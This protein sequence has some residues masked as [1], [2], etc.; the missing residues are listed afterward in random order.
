M[1]RIIATLLLV[2]T[3]HAVSAQEQSAV[4]DTIIYTPGKKTIS[5]TQVISFAPQ[6]GLPA[7]SKVTTNAG[8]TIS[9]TELGRIRGNL[10]VSPS[11][12]ATYAIRFTLPPGIGNVIPDLGL[13]YNSQSGNGTAG[14]GWN[15]SGL[16]EIKRVNATKFHDNTSGSINFNAQDRFELNGQRL[17]LK[18]GT[19]GTDGAEYITEQSSN[20]RIVSRGILLFGTGTGPAY[21]E[22]FYPDGSKATYGSS[23]DSAAAVTS[24]AYGISSLVNPQN[25]RI[26]YYYQKP[27]NTLLIS[28]IAYG[29]RT[30][31]P[32][33][34]VIN[35]NYRPSTRIEQGYIGGAKAFRD[36]I[37]NDVTI[38]ANGVPYRNYTLLHDNMTYHSYERLI[39]LTESNGNNTA[40]LSPVFFTYDETQFVTVT[41]TI[42][43]LSLSGIA[44]NNASILTA[45]F[46]GNGKMDFILYPPAKNKLFVFWDPDGSSPYSAYNMGYQMTVNFEC[47]LPV[48]W[49]T[50]NNKVL[51]GEGF[52]L[53]SQINGGGHN[54]YPPV[55]G[56]LPAPDTQK[57]VVYSSG[58]VL[59]VY[60]QYERKWV[61]D[62]G[63]TAYHSYITNKQYFERNF[64]S[65]EWLSGD[66]DGD[67]LSDVIGISKPW[68]HRRFERD[69]GGSP[70]YEYITKDYSR[71]DFVNID[72]RVTTNFVTNSGVLELPL[73]GPYSIKTGDFN[74][75]GKTDFMQ[76][77]NGTFYV[78]SFNENKALVKLFQVS[79][80][81]ITTN[82]PA[83][84][85]DYNG[86]GKMDIIFPAGAGSNWF[87]AF[88]ATGK[89]F[90]KTEKSY[91]F[92]YRES[93]YNG[94]TTV[95]N[96][97]FLVSNDID[98]D[99]K[100]D[101]MEM[102]TVSTNGSS[103][104]SMDLKTW[105]NSNPVNQGPNLT[106]KGTGTTAN[107]NGNIRHYPIPVFFNSERPNFNLELGVLSDNSFSLFTFQKDARKETMLKTIQE[108]SLKFTIDYSP[109]MPNSSE[110]FLQLYSTTMD[111]TFPNIDIEQATGLSVVKKLKRKFNGTETQ[112]RFGYRGAVINTE[113]LGFLGFTENIQTNWH[114]N[115]YDNNRIYE[116]QVQ[117]PELRG[118]PVKIFV[119][120]QEYINPTVKNAPASSD[121]SSLTDYV[122]RVDYTYNTSLLSNKIFINTPA[123]I[124][125]KNH[126]TAASSTVS[127]TYDSYN[128]IVT[129]EKSSGTAGTQLTSNVF[130]NNPASG[131]VGRL[132]NRTITQS[133]SSG[134]YTSEE[135][136]TYTSFLPSQV[137]RRGHNTSF[138]TED[139]QYDV[140]GNVIQKTVTTAAGVRTD[141]TEYDPSGRFIT[142]LTTPD[143]KE[144]SFTYNTSTG[145]PITK[146]EPDNKTFNYEYDNWGRWI[147]KTDFLG[148]KSFRNF[149]SANGFMTIHESNADSML[150]STRYNCIGQVVEIKSKDATGQI[151]G[152]A[153][154][155]DIYGRKY[156]ESQPAING[157]YT[158]WD[159]KSF[160]NYGRPL[161]ISYY[162]G[163]T[164]T[165][166]YA[167]ASTTV[168]DGVKSVT[169]TRNSLGQVMS[170]QDPG[171]TIAYS[172]F[173][174][175]NLQTTTYNGLTQTIEQDGWGRKTK[176]T[177][178]SAGIYT[179]AY[180]E[181]NDI[182]NET[183]PKGSI[184][185]TYDV[186]GK[187]LS[188]SIQGDNTD[189][190]YTYTYDPSTKLLSSLQL[191]NADGNNAQ[192]TYTYDEH[193]RISN[194]T[195]DNTYA[196][197]NKTYTYTASGRVNTLTNEAKHK[198]SNTTFTMAEKYQYTNG[199]LTSIFDN[200]TN[201]ELWKINTLNARGQVT[202]A[203]NSVIGINRVFDQYGY[204]ETFTST[205]LS[206]STELMQL[207]FTYDAQKGNLSSR[208]NDALSWNETFTY[209]NLN[210]LTDFNDNDANHAQGYDNQ[211]RISS[212]SKLGD[213]TYQGN[214]YQPSAINNLTSFANGY[215]Q[216]RALLQVTYNSFRSPVTI[217]EQGKETIS[218]QYNALLNRAHM[219]FG[220]QETNPLQR[221]FHRHYSEDGS[222][223][224]TNDALNNK[225]SFV[226]YVGGNAYKAPLIWKVEKSGGTVTS[227]F[228]YL[229]RDPQGS[230]FLITDAAGTIKE[231]RQ[232]DAWGKLVRLTD[233]TN[234]LSGFVILDR[235]YTGHEHLQGVMLINMNKRL[236]DPVL[237][238]FL[239]PDNFVQ[240]PHFSQ[241]FNRYGYAMNN[242]FNGTD[243]S[244]DFFIIDSWIIGFVSSL[245]NGGSLKDAFNEGNR[246]A[247][248]DV[249]I[250]AG[251]F[252]TDPNKSFWQRLGEFGSRLTWQLPQTIG[253][254]LFS[255]SVNTFGLYGGVE[256]VEYLYGAT[257]VTTKA[258]SW[259]AVTQGSFIVGNKNLKADANNP[260]FQHEYGHYLQSQKFGWAYYPRV[261]IPSAMSDPSMHSYHPVE[262]D[263]NRRAFIYFNKNVP[264][265]MND[266]KADGSGYE[267]THED[268]LQNKG[269]DYKSNPL[270]ISGNNVENT[271]PIDP[272]NPNQMRLLDALKISPKWFDFAGWSSVILPVIIGIANANYYQ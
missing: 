172:Y 88:L 61:D 154:Q 256:S 202:S 199:Q 31:S 218:F 91:P 169:T 16:S 2:M 219:H 130:D 156:K 92:Y 220:G 105:Y 26:D 223:E 149:T 224:I 74:G 210:R 143:G 67:G 11:G 135:Q 133:N 194:V 213:I 53:T 14:Y 144:T 122:S 231:K 44:G 195:E 81:R 72:R 192:Y 187:L 182:T 215:F 190:G 236:Y 250:Y 86:D 17:I 146:K 57:I 221:R 170:V 151:V 138:I 66:F 244:G 100:T 48:T 161:Q 98:K 102:H 69:G 129:E 63:L 148:M 62:L 40:S 152:R 97:Y 6:G 25:V 158:Q 160:D 29:H 167:G 204:P 258:E 196:R 142:K 55:G 49:L 164:T 168:N 163:K 255:Q 59:P 251:L 131:Y 126:L 205:L 157:N 136:F 71:V 3:A 58:Y 184:D 173:A 241:S 175:G 21:F 185:F 32:A 41:N 201:Q 261:G 177:D 1:K 82:Y 211:G 200:S 94:Q 28:S 23:T 87:T 140:F 253:G 249:R 115:D 54:Y 268:P 216:D 18:S 75:D 180:N 246:R 155:Y 46:T 103:Q 238:R 159:E 209:D 22:V 252:K 229:H 243:P 104:G 7:N 90:E 183:N 37:L 114:I 254:L 108:D 113:G 96:S 107:F 121:G 232:F 15:V 116:V 237:H 260:L 139:L 35:F 266:H 120:K 267:L 248:N 198:A 13:A 112:K 79:D 19:Y 42:T 99:G 208:T 24:S 9:T 60:Y 247:Q 50:H 272:N 77:V 64:V 20:I 70:Y 33:L 179:Y 203:G 181:F 264:G 110:P 38:V 270:K 119:A 166:T 191:T 125:S 78:Y 123:S 73:N 34:N 193:K 206:T 65:R 176:L 47:I 80:V 127:F 8:S 147:E 118:A 162:T 257:V 10:E 101:I 230:I 227:D 137:K 240:N 128:N 150:N 141:L 214:A 225:N 45:D 217:T 30:N 153:I 56:N 85:G 106:F 189:M 43:N 262:Q 178:P 93:D 51:A 36:K 239:S 265:F 12:G 68:T 222:M 132:T 52:A 188:K 39:K 174:N 226:F 111:K 84:M 117:S 124:H 76:I 259:E 245:F 5:D 235:G 271:V 234:I 89:S 228:Y 145:N 4:S 186:F 197:F 233:G 109:L 83:L 95:M 207:H 165:F 171:G 242:P 134:T 212:I 263:A 27:G 269:W